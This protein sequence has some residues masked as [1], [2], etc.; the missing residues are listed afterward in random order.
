M[1]ALPNHGPKGPQWDQ[2]SGL[3]GGQTGG[4]TLFL[5][6]TASCPCW[7]KSSAI[8]RYDDV[9][10]GCLPHALLVYAKFREDLICVESDS[11]LPFRPRTSVRRIPDHISLT[12]PAIPLP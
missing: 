2:N 7:S 6:T 10:F 9:S 8:S 12:A 3:G 5:T 4:T 1:A 11:E